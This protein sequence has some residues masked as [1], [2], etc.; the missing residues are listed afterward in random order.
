MIARFAIVVVTLLTTGSAFAE[1]LTADAARRFVAGKLFAF[2]CFDGSRGAGRIYGDGSVIGNIQFRGAGPVKQVWLPAGTLRVRGESVCASLQGIPFEPCFNLDKMDERSFRGSVSGFGFA[3][4]DFTRPERCRRHER[5]PAL[6]GAG[7]ARH[8]DGRN[9]RLAP[10]DLSLDRQR[11]G[12]TIEPRARIACAR[13]V[14]G[15]GQL[16]DV[17]PPRNASCPCPSPRRRGYPA[18]GR[19]GQCSRTDGKTTGSSTPS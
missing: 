1:T 8:G 16:H 14:R 12:R 11:A 5:A 18:P 9:H 4:C 3:Y 15:W 19:A 6:V 2:N 13:T 10:T 7:G 17:A